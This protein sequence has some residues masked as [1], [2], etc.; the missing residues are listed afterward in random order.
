MG[1]AHT[2]SASGLTPLSIKPTHVARVS[3]SS[4]VFSSWEMSNK[5]GCPRLGNRIHAGNMTPTIQSLL[6][7]V[8]AV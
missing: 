8:D 7:R 5:T 1:Q 6:R 2:A 3:L 4:F